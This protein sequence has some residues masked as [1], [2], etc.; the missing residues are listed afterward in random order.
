MKTGIHI[1]NKE[2]T[3]VLEKSIIA[4]LKAVKTYQTSDVVAIK[5][6]DTL[7]DAHATSI[8]ISNCTFE[9]TP[10]AVRVDTE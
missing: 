5:A 1:D 4:I 10:N 9:S 7:E 3:K 2:A 6:L 8:E